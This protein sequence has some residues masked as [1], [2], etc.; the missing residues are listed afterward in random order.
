MKTNTIRKGFSAV[1]AV[2]I[3]VIIVIIGAL[4]YVFYNR[5][6]AQP[7]SDTNS[8]PQT[9]TEAKAET[10][11]VKS[12]LEAVDIDKELD[13]SEIDAALE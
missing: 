6:Q 10:A 11:D 12:D 13:T 1:E 4:G 2:I 5:M 3:V 9:A 7:A 8:A